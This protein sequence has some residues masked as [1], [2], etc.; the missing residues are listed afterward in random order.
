MPTVMHVANV[1]N[2]VHS[3]FAAVNGLGIA[4]LSVSHLGIEH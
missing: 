3:F 1:Q 4:A 2:T